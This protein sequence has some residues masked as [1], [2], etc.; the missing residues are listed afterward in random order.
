MVEP[1]SNPT[2]PFLSQGEPATDEALEDRR[3]VELVQEY[4]SQLEQGHTPNRAEFISRFPELS[5]AVAQCLDGL[6]LV[7]RGVSS[8]SG[9]R[10]AA[11]S[12]PSVEAA[13]ALGD[14]QI[15][16]E[17]ARGGMGIVYEAVQLSLGRRVAL[18]VLP[19]AATLDERQLQ[20]FKNEAQAA[21]LLH[22]THI[23]PIY[24]V[25]CER[26]VHFYAMQLIDGQS[27]AVV[28]RELREES[29]VRGAAAAGPPVPDRAAPSPEAVPLL[30]TNI[31]AAMTA[32]ASP[33]SEIYFRRM[34]RL[35]VQAADALEHAHQ[36]GVIHRD[37]K[38]GN[39]LVNAAGNLWVTDFGLAQF[40]V[41]TGLTRTGD[42]VGTLRYM[43]PEQT[44]GQRTPLDQRTDIYSL[45]A[46]FYELFTLEPVFPGETRQELLYQI[47]HEEPRAPRALNRAIPAELEIILLKSLSKNPA[48]RYGSAA[49]LSA[50]VQRYLDNKPILAR[51]PTVFDRMRKWSRRHPSVVVAGMLLLFVVSVGL[52]ISNRLI[53]REQTKTND[54]LEREKLRANE[55][56][57]SFRLA[58]Q[59]VDVLIAISEDELGDNPS[60]QST[61]RRMLEIA[62]GYYQD[63]IE[64]RQGDT[65]TQA[66]LAAVRERVR[67]MLYELNMVQR[68]LDT[69]LL[70]NPLVQDALSLDDRQKPRLA[71]LLQQWSQE[72]DRFRRE[73]Q[74]ADEAIRRKRSVEI[75]EAH[76]KA[77]AELL[78]PSQ[79]K[80]LKQISVQSHGL[81]AFNDPDVVQALGLSPAQ[82]Q[83]IRE[84]ERSFFGRFAGPPGRSFGP[85]PGALRLRPT[86]EEGIAKVLAILTEEQRQSWQELTG[87]PVEGIGEPMFRGPPG[88]GPP[89]EMHGPHR[90]PRGDN[91]RPPEPPSQRRAKF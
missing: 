3:I 22:H 84:I 45:G 26:G 82:R 29:P 85:G 7:Y 19:F 71:E 11:L 1:D 53:S 16:R 5:D 50:D 73:T 68:E 21:A 4:Q 86:R 87:T 70:H 47:L 77:L 80:R 12:H 28:I 57:E 83:T 9:R 20:R 2:S 74:D 67:R 32:G 64:Q 76:D 36:L 59:A 79:Q 25:G 42:L 60:V 15:V 38:P 75:A 33:V 49:E 40:Q 61:R 78:S 23:V 69:A 48:E 13:T 14:F 41:D 24:A 10:G 81:F 51:R 30:S 72:R 46:T 62:L 18:K 89:D 17:L 63:F 39:L 54:A 66:D 27:L 55:V 88:F 43:S 90:F 34:A 6:E 58:R 52:S 65:A 37:I 31:S 91:G 56:E 44:S 35:M 8:S